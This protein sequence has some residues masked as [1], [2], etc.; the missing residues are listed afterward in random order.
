MNL[1]L[2]TGTLLFSTLSAC[3][4]T[5][6]TSAVVIDKTFVTQDFKDWVH[7]EALGK[8]AQLGGSCKIMNI[9]REYYSCSVSR[10]DAIDLGF[11]FTTKG[12]YAI[13]LSSTVAHLWPPS[14]A[15]VI[16]GKHVPSLQIELEEWIVDTIPDEAIVRRTR[17]IADYVYRESF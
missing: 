7:S 1:K 16:A 12:D 6:T 10:D 4:Q 5:I 11:G 9:E 14:D 3:S 17:S 8:V 15:S 2:L 13:L